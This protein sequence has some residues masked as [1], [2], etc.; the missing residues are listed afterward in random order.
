[1]AIQMA[2]VGRKKSIGSNMGN[3][4]PASN[5]GTKGML[6]LRPAMIEKGTTA[7]VTSNSLTTRLMAIALEK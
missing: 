3:G 7:A 2:R 6:G 4:I 1:M 5:I